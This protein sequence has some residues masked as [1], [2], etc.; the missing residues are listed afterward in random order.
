M[1]QKSKRKGKDEWMEKLFAHLEAQLEEWRVEVELQ[2]RLC[3][4]TDE[5]DWFGHTEADMLR[6]VS[7]E[8]DTCNQ[9]ANQNIPC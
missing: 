4:G 1:A 5:S 8:Q 7:E 2:Q 3:Q 6:R 9:G